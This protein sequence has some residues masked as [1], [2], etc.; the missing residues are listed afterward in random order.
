MLHDVVLC[1]ETQPCLQAL[2]GKRVDVLCYYGV[3]NIIWRRG[4]SSLFEE[5]KEWSL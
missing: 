3:N 4:D 2:K 5:R 1:Q